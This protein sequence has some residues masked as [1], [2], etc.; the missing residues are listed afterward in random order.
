MTKE[1]LEVAGYTIYDLKE[2]K[3]MCNSVGECQTFEEASDRYMQLLSFFENWQHNKI[4]LVH[5]KQ[6]KNNL[7]LTGLSPWQ[8]WDK[9]GWNIAAKQ[10]Q[11]FESV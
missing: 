1:E 10:F 5:C 2:V 8:W 3:A 7:W 4:E 11:K 6:R 9:I